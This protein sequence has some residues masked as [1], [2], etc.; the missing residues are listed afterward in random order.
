[1]DRCNDCISRA[2]ASRI[3]RGS[4]FESRLAKLPSVTPEINADELCERVLKRLYANDKDVFVWEA[5]FFN[6]GVLATIEALKEELNRPLEG[7]KNEF[8]R[9]KQRVEKAN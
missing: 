6:D 5:K 1:M 4:I 3:A 9:H 8:A 7:G 2:E